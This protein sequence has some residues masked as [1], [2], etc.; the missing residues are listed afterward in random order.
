MRIVLL[1][2]AL[3]GC[4]SQNPDALRERVGGAS[5][6]QLCRAVFLAPGEVAQIAQDE[7]QR[8]SLDCRPYASAVFQNE[9]QANAAR[10]ALAWRL[11]TPPPV[12]Q[13]RSCNS[14]RVGNTI[15]TDCQ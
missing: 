4:A 2:L 1:C 9:A 10:N 13:M 5:N 14:Y 15:Q 8:R 7:A 11:L 12:Q 6:F 3:A